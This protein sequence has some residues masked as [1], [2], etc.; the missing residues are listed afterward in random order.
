MLRALMS[1]EKQFFLFF[2]KALSQVF[3]CV[4]RGSLPL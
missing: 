4:R 3:R 1:G 2:F